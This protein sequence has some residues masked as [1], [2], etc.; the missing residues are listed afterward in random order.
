M[1]LDRQESVLGS[2]HYQPIRDRAFSFSLAPQ[3]VK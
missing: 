1:M 2:F 3:I